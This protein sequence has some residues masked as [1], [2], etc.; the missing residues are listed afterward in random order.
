MPL[1]T[2]VVAVMFCCIVCA[3]CVVYICDFHR[4]QC[5]LRW[6]ALSKHGVSAVRDELLAMLRNV[7]RAP[8]VKDYDSAVQHLRKSKIWA[9]CAALQQWFSNKWLPEHKVIWFTV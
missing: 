9:R 6:T 8:T 5:W 2:C 4:E 3:D 1:T 7:A